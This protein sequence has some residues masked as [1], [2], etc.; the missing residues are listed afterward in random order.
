MTLILA[1]LSRGAQNIIDQ[2]DTA[3][4][5]LATR[6]QIQVILNQIADD[7]ETLLRQARKAADDHRVLEDLP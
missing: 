3:D 6:E 1:R 2:C 4:D 5:S 7:C